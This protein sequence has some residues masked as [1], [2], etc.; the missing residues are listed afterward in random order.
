MHP[1]Y[2]LI[3]VRERFDEWT[4]HMAYALNNVLLDGLY[5]EF[6]VYK[7]GTLNFMAPRVPNQV[8]HGFDSF[9]GLREEWLQNPIDHL[10]LN[11]VPPDISHKNVL[12]HVGT[13]D[14]TLAP[15]VAE[16]IQNAAFLHIDSDTYSSTKTI[17]AAFR[18]LIVS[19]TVLVFDEFFT[20][21][22]TGDEAQ[23]FYE[24]IRES[25][26]G[27]IFLSHHNR[28]GSVSAVVM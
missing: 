13:F 6:G 10:D 23:A 20:G 24:F 14:E 5:C 18:P 22:T 7:G 2:A 11:G 27:F 12:L 9:R 28:G 25:G 17:F 8:F 16:Q 4:D 1:S 15:F 21:A 19:G 26:Y 3:K